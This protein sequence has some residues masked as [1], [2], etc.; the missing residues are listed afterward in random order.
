MKTI[1]LLLTILLLPV[2]GYTQSISRLQKMTESSNET[3]VVSRMDAMEIIG[4]YNY[5]KSSFIITVE[6]MKI[7]NEV[8]ENYKKILLQQSL[9][10]K[11]ISEE[12]ERL[13]VEVE[14]LKKQVIDK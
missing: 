7:S 9:E 12:N 5:M 8:L 13:K 3:I 2:I 10:I 1:L 11:K 6:E 4:E 14:E